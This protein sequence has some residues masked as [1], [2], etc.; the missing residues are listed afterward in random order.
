MEKRIISCGSGPKPPYVCF[1]IE[2]GAG[3][4]ITYAAMKKLSGASGPLLANRILKFGKTPLQAIKQGIARSHHYYPSRKKKSIPP[5]K[6]AVKKRVSWKNRV[7]VCFRKTSEGLV[8]CKNY[9]EW[10]KPKNDY[11]CPCLNGFKP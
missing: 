5:K 4:F 7:E 11:Q 6:I 2:P 1:E 10:M 9:E 3:I 8:Q